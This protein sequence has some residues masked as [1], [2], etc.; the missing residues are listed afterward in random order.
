MLYIF[1]QIALSSPVLTAR[2]IS[3]R[4][5]T[6]SSAKSHPNCL[7]Y[8]SRLLSR[9]K[10]GLLGDKDIELPLLSLEIMYKR[11]FGFGFATEKFEPP[12]VKYL[13]MQNC[14]SGASFFFAIIRRIQL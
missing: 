5:A 10:I 14:P 2:F 13:S 11:S 3:P 1:I 8:I 9:L 4:T 12:A 6:L 7:F